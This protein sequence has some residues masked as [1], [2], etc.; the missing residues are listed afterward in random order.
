M[1]KK[2]ADLFNLP[3]N[4]PSDETQIAN[5]LDDVPPTPPIEEQQLTLAS[6]DATIDKIDQAMPA[7]R[8]L[9]RSDEEMDEL[10]AMAKNAA[11]DL[12]DLGMAMEARFS[13]T[14]FQTAGVLLGHA[15]SA[16][17]AKI[18]KKLKMLDLQMKKLGLDHKIKREN[19]KDQA[20]LEAA[21]VGEDDPIDGDGQLIDRNALLAELLKKSTQSENDK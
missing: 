8:G 9:E 15:I 7:V 21:G 18:D 17:Q 3:D 12:M 14:V 6:L 2:L 16:K 19:A 4:L 13:G 11:Q 5:S 20:A 1:S 10:S